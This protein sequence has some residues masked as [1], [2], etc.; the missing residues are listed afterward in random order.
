M[1]AT[2][3]YVHEL[4]SWLG[5]LW[6]TNEPIHPELFAYVYEQS[7]LPIVVMEDVKLTRMS[8]YNAIREMPIWAIP[9]MGLDQN[10]ILSLLVD[11]TTADYLDPEPQED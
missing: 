3:T 10:D 7:N 8:A 4:E 11:A 5:A 9:S 2:E 1:T 6:D